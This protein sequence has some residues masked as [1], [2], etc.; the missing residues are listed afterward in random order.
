[1]DP[2]IE[3]IYVRFQGNETHADKICKCFP[4]CY[5]LALHTQIHAMDHEDEEEDDDNNNTTTNNNDDDNDDHD[6]DDVPQQKTNNN[7]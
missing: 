3:N 7:T 5:C 1:M 6:G 2:N 4:S